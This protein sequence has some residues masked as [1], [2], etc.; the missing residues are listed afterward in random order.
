MIRRFF[1]VSLLLATPVLSEDR[2]TLGKPAVKVAKVEL[3][4]FPKVPA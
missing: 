3:I 1:I 4:D 2:P